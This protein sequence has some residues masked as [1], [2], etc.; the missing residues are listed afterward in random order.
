MALYPPGAVPVTN[1][2]LVCPLHLPDCNR[3]PVI[4]D[5]LLFRDA[6]SS[7]IGKAY[8]D[9]RFAKG[10]IIEEAIVALDNQ[11]A[12]D[13]ALLD[14]KISGVRRADNLQRLRKRFPRL[15]KYLPSVSGKL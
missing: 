7:A 15:S 13:L 1:R 8:P 10:R 12:F 6:S 2:K 14:L 5:H 4:D 11:V 3:I 9:A